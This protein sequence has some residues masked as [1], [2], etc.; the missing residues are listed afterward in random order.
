MYVCMYI[1]IYIYTHTIQTNTTRAVPRL[2]RHEGRGVLDVL[3]TA[4]VTGKGSSSSS[5]S[6]SS[7]DRNG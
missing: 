2:L 7:S 6:S 1:Y 3:R 5:S 4:R